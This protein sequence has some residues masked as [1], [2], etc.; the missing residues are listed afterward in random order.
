[1]TEATMKRSAQVALV[2]MTA[3]TVGGGAYSMM[4]HQNCVTSPSGAPNPSVA[5][6][7]CG[8]GGSSGGGGHGSHTIFGSSGS[9][10]G[11]GA[12]G[13][14][15]TAGTQRGGFGGSFHSIGSHMSSLGG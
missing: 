15:N 9:R 6:S 4:P 8:S 3:A 2:V 1:L 14:G 13:S 5:G 7:S 12:G 10:D 11:T